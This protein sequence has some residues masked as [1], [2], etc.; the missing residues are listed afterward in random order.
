MDQLRREL[1]KAKQRSAKA[2]ESVD[3]QRALILDF[4]KNRRDTSM[5]EDVLRTLIEAQHLYEDAERRLIEEL[6]EVAP[7]EWRSNYAEKLEAPPTNKGNKLLNSLSL[8]DLAL[9]QPFLER[10]GLKFRSRLQM[11]NRTMKTIHFPESGM[12]SVMAV[13]GGGRH[14]TQIGLIGREGMTGMPIIFGSKRSPFDIEVEIEGQGQCIAS[15]KL[16][17][18]MGQCPAIRTA[19]VGYLQTL[20]LQ[21]AHTAAANANGTLEQRLAR[22]LLL[23]EERLESEEIGLTHEQLATLL[24]VRRAGVTVALQHLESS[25]LIERQRATVTIRDRAGLRAAASPLN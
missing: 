2:R 23:V 6:K 9:I 7:Q 5:A 8:S 10:V 14:K 18:L 24:S 17:D 11:A 25:R 19:V 20:W 1:A 16:I 12:I 22:L 15:K 4:E 13:N 21:F 3:R